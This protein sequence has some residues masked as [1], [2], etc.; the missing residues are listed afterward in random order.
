MCVVRANHAKQSTISKTG[1]SSYNDGMIIDL[2]FAFVAF[3]TGSK[4]RCV[5]VI[6]YMRV[7]I[8]VRIANCEILV[9]ICTLTIQDTVAHHEHN[10]RTNYM[11]KVWT[12]R[13][14]EREHA[15]QSWILFFA[16]SYNLFFCIAIDG[17][18]K[19]RLR[20]SDDTIVI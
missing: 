18:I 10:Q 8:C 14:R 6:Q 9:L 11:N 19:Q 3:C 13:E 17:T 16:H 12:Y 5:Y 1:Q 2:W 4:Y 20:N 15:T 7:S